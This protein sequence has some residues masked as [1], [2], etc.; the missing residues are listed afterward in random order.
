M[1][2][3][4]SFDESLFRE[5]RSSTKESLA[6]IAANEEEADKIEFEVSESRKKVSL[7]VDYSD[8]S[9]HIFYCSAL[10]SVNFA[11]GRILNDYPIDGELKEKNEWRRVNS[12]YENYFF[13][14]YPKRQGFV[15]FET[16]SLAQENWV[17]FIDHEQKLSPGTGSFAVDMIV[18]PDIAIDETT[19]QKT[20]FSYKEDDDSEG[21][22]AYFDSTKILN[23]KVASGSSESVLTSSYGPFI[24][25]SHAL[26]F[27]YDAPNNIQAIYLDG[28]VL[29][30]QSMTTTF[31]SGVGEVGVL[32]S[33]RFRIG[34][35]SSSAASSAQVGALFTGAIDDVRVW[36]GPV[37]KSELIK[38]NFFKPT[39]ANFSGG[40]K[41]YYK[42]NEPEEIGTRV[43]D[44][45]GNGHHG[46]L[47]GTTA[48]FSFSQNIRSGTLGP[49]FKDQGDPIFALNN[50]LVDSFVTEQRTSGSNF[51]REN[52]NYIFRIV[53]SYFIDEGE[54]HED[55]QRFLLLIARHYDRLK[56]YIRHL[57]NV[58][59]VDQ[60]EADNTPDDLIGLVAQ[61]YGLDVG[62]VYEGAGA[63]QYFFGEDVLPTGS[64]GEPVQKIKNQLRRNLLSNLIFIIK[65]K[66]TREALEASIR[67]LGLDEEV[68]NIN[69][70]SVFSGGIE[71]VRNL[72][73]VERKVADFTTSSVV[74][75][76]DDALWNNNSSF[77][78]LNER[79]YEM[80]VQFNTASLNTT[81][82]VF[83]FF[84][85][86]GQPNF[87]LEVER[88][89]TT[90]SLGTAKLYFTTGALGDGIAISSSNLDFF[91][92][93]WINFGATI[94]TSP[95]VTRIGLHV[96][97]FDR[98]EIAFS[99][100]V[101]GSQFHLAFRLSETGTL[102]TREGSTSTFSGKMQEYRAWRG[103]LSQ[104]IFVQHTKDF[105]SL[106]TPDFDSDFDRLLIHHKL[107]DFTGSE[108]GIVPLHDYACAVTGTIFSGVS[109]EIEVNFP[110]VY[111]TKLEPA[112]SYD[113]AIN[114]DKVRIRDREEFNSADVIEDIPYLSVDMSPTVALNKEILKWFGDIDQFNQIIGQPFL[115]YREEVDTLN[116]LR[117]NFFKNRVNS[118]INF[119]LYLKLLKWFDSNFTFFLEQLIP[120]DLGSSLSNFVIE[121]HLL[122][123][124]QV[125]RVFPY[126][127]GRSSLEITGAVD[128]RQAVSVAL[129]ADD[130]G[131]ADPGRFGA[132]VSASAEVNDNNLFDFTSSLLS[133]FQGLNF[134]N[135]IDRR[136]FTDLLQED[137]SSYNPE[138]YGNGWY[139]TVITGS[140]YMK[141]VL[142]ADSSFAISGVHFLTGSSFPPQTDDGI[143]SLYL[144]SN[145]ARP[146]NLFFTGQLNGVQDQRWLWYGEQENTI[147]DAIGPKHDHGI[148]YGGAWGQ[149]WKVNNKSVRGTVLDLRFNAGKSSIFI[150]DVVVGVG[151]GGSSSVV[152]PDRFVSIKEETED[153]K[154]FILW[155]SLNAFE[156]VRI[157]NTE[158]SQTTGSFLL[159]D[160]RNQI[161]TGNPNFL[162]ANSFGERIPI[163]GGFRHLDVSIGAKRLYVSGAAGFD[164]TPIKFKFLF[165]FFGRGTPGP[166]DFEST[167]TSSV[168][169]GGFFQNGAVGRIG[170]RRRLR[171]I[172]EFEIEQIAES[173]TGEHDFVAHFE[174]ELPRARFMRTFVRIEFPQAATNNLAVGYKIQI[175][176]TLHK[177]T[178]EVQRKFTES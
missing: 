41:L 15:F 74:I 52:R 147:R 24:S 165:Q 119:D 87:Y 150:N 112:Y 55:M 128:A 58:Y 43:F 120:L 138:G 111:L 133:G 11:L 84:T 106:V 105:E 149:L 151:G 174:R 8:F 47:T 10:A 148:G 103:L 91:D 160:G 21:F 73:T 46:E 141:N 86:S 76:R 142:N 68:V 56:L 23:F 77:P 139:T 27:V 99:E 166:R 28:E 61:H 173:E 35:M 129:T 26:S 164:D 65:T 64:L 156:P 12:G 62:N 69:E 82:S 113:I 117:A 170:L 50:T 48:T 94:D 143:D 31:P 79:S 38:R 134:A 42:F 137:S 75:L 44:Y 71:P 5:F 155:P 154:T 80:R 169:P 18:E 90:A 124:N 110:G 1:A 51:D 168:I 13:D 121:S 7:R 57:A 96:N 140:D 178:T 144:T 32:N 122:E 17:E 176:G 131:L 163:T 104:S 89:N 19:H 4:N 60:G 146:E 93:K 115:R 116:H 78:E 9:N 172:Q 167:L 171:Q 135:D 53:P 67:S 107:N 161:D 175:K 14:V 33:N 16:G 45:S 123:F 54:V 157:T 159:L 109:S 132:A 30:S 125:P 102:G 22:W 101:S 29:V 108:S 136:I 85:G 81:A 2:N 95:T 66:S 130:F 126:K 25:Q 40:L 36:V 114:K 92:N 158:D 83:S 100:S 34:A 162:L 6:D 49:W 63:L 145:Y 59:N 20:L 152:L 70:Y 98:D 88:N 97:S 177:E 39:H 3:F 127:K 37:R 72:R 118:K 153:T